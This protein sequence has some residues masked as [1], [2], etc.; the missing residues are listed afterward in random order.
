MYISLQ[1]FLKRLLTWYLCHKL[2]KTIFRNYAHWSLNRTQLICNY[3][4][5]FYFLWHKVF[6]RFIILPKNSECFRFEKLLETE[7]AT[8]KQR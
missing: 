4:K 6:F 2:A 5:K 8:A 1:N 7:P 3:D